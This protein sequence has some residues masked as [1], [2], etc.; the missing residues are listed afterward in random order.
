MF[1]FKHPAQDA[2]AS[3]P[4]TEEDPITYGQALEEVSNE[5]NKAVKAAQEAERAEAEKA[6]NAKMAEMEAKMAA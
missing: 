2:T 6:M 4:D 1:I 3:R 5:E